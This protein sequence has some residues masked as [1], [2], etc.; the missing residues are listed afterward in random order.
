[1]R[2]VPEEV[3]PRARFEDA[4]VMLGVRSFARIPRP[5]NR[6]LA[7]LIGASGFAATLCSLIRYVYQ[8]ALR[9][10]D[11]PLVST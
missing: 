5:A 7:S 2:A 8:A 3:A 10:D 4:A 11:G 1:M 6:V 9:R